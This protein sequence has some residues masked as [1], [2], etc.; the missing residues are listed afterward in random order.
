MT[1][2]IWRIAAKHPYIS[3]ICQERKVNKDG[4]LASGDVRMYL[5][6]ELISIDSKKI[7]A[8]GFRTGGLRFTDLRLE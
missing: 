6:Y 3:C 7:I 4:N 8:F 1:T 5:K 2:A